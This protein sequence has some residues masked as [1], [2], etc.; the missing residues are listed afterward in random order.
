MSRGH[1]SSRR[2][3][4]GSRQTELRHRRDDGRI[5]EAEGPASWPRGSGWDRESETPAWLHPV[6]ASDASGGQAQAR[7]GPH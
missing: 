3:N 7:G 2:R 5:R 6:D 4:Y 1:S